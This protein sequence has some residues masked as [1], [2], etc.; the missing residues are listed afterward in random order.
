MRAAV[1]LDIAYQA[2][3]GTGAPILEAYADLVR[4]AARE[5]F[6]DKQDVQSVTVELIQEN[7][8]AIVAALEATLPAAGSA[9]ADRAVR[10]LLQARQKIDALLPLVADLGRPRAPP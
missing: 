6:G 2:A 7:S 5:R 8:E 1:R 4:I 9:E 10:E 3:G